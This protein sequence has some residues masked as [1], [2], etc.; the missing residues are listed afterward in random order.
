MTVGERRLR[1][2]AELVFSESRRDGRR[3]VK[4][5][6]TCMT[7]AL[8]LARWSRARCLRQVFEPLQLFTISASCGPL[9][10]CPNSLCRRLLN[11]HLP[12]HRPPPHPDF[13][14]WTLDFRLWAAG[15]G[16]K[17][18][19]R[20]SGFRCGCRPARPKG[21]SP[22]S[23]IWP[24]SQDRRKTARSLEPCPNSNSNLGSRPRDRVFGP[25]R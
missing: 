14:P 1:R 12:C 8:A 25:G 5:K 20:S 21:P 9:N 18:P 23:I 7:L 24:K 3:S 2:G 4:S 13:G 15:C 10:K 19:S 17:R 22:H 6:D 11:A 16:A